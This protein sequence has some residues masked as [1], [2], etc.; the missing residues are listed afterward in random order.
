MTQTVLIDKAEGVLTITLNRP[1]K[2]NALNA[3]MY[4]SI[5]DALNGANDDPEVRVVLVQAEGDMFTAGQ[6][7]SEFAA[8]NAGGVSG[9]LSA[10]ALL[11][12]LPGLTKPLVAAVQG[13]AVGIGLTLLLHCDLVYVADNALL[14]CPFVDLGLSPEAA[15]SLLL[16]ARIGHVRAFQ[17]LAFGETIDGRT[18]AQWGIANAALPASEVR[19]KA[20]SAA[21]ALA[22]KPAA[23]VRA[24]KEMMRDAAAL[25]ERVSE[26]LV[27]FLAQ[28]Q[29][30]EAKEAFRAFFEKRPPDF[31]QF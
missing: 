25:E 8:L 19:G 5:A 16:P 4:R 18:A 30:P 12:A 23:A 3:E 9:E 27:H 6:D 17:L 15:S 21:R 2:K 1:E 26:E 13:R 10:E 28:L 22:G 11:K 20:R 31:S 14:S 7:I 29:S 24:N